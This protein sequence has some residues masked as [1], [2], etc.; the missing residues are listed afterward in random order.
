LLD[1]T[2]NTVVGQESEPPPLVLEISHPSAEIGEHILLHGIG[3]TQL[4]GIVLVLK[5]QP[6][7]GAISPKAKL[8]CVAGALESVP[9]LERAGI[10]RQRRGATERL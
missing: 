2:S 9:K 4:E 1:S 8:E 10:L 5:R 6:L 3:G 7:E